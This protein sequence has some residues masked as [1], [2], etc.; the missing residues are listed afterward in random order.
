MGSRTHAAHGVPRCRNEG[1]RPAGEEGGG[2]DDNY[3]SAWNRCSLLALCRCR[4]SCTLFVGSMKIS[5]C[6][7]NTIYTVQTCSHAGFWMN[8]PAR[9]RGGVGEDPITMCRGEN[10]CEAAGRS[11]LAGLVGRARS[12]FGDRFGP[13]KNPSLAVPK[14]P[15]LPHAFFGWW[16]HRP[17]LTQATPQSASTTAHTITHPLLSFSLLLPPSFLCVLLC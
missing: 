15:L 11:R 5:Q 12:G 17:E 10:G 13:W 1:M 3:S 14:A 9:A 4:R 8:S 2:D 7:A 16:N 6:K